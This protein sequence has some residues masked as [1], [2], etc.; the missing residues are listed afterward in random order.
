MRFQALFSIF[1]CSEL[2]HSK[3]FRTGHIIPH[4]HFL[5]ITCGLSPLIRIFE[6]TRFFDF[7]TG[8]IVLFKMVL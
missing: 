5:S 6:K 8:P 4:E 1:K 3:G 7:S 2:R